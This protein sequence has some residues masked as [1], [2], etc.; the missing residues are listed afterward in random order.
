MAKGRPQSGLRDGIEGAELRQVPLGFGLGQADEGARVPGRSRS[1]EAGRHDR[2][3][4]EA[5][6]VGGVERGAIERWKHGTDPVG[7]R[8]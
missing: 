3:R 8:A 5:L 4:V 2:R 7:R 1:R 6:A